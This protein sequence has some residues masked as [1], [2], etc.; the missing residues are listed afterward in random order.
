M[1]IRR[2]VVED[3]S[4]VLPLVRKICELHQQWDPQRFGFRDDVLSSYDRWMR[5]RADDPRSVFLVAESNGQIVAYIISTIEEEIPIYRTRECG[6]I[7]DLWVEPQYRNEGLARQMVTLTVE[8]FT[9]LGIQQIR[10][11]TA[12]MNETARNL[13]KAC[14]FRVATMEML[15]ESESETTDE[16]G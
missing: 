14:G 4:K 12:A 6:W 16:Q 10:L 8:R 13:F 1:T 3:V 2:A 7:H 5:Q 15:H 9:E 11:Q